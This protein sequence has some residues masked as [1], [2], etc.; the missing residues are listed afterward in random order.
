ML[1]LMNTNIQ[2]NKLAND[3][4]HNQTSD[5][6]VRAFASSAPQHR[7]ETSH[8]LAGTEGFGNLF[9][10]SKFKSDQ[11]INLLNLGRDHQVRHVRL[12]ANA[13]CHLES[14]GCRDCQVEQN[15]VQAA[16]TQQLERH[17]LHAQCGNLRHAGNARAHPRRAIHLRR[18]A[19]G[20]TRF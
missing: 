4:R 3:P 19:P 5:N 6:A 12:A 8:H 2:P 18:S 7:L 15:H 16:G 10:V 17:S 1:F 14:V 9:V 11:A 13:P 20:Q